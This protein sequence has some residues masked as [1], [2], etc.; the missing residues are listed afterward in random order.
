[1]TVR[2]FT[3]ACGADAVVNKPIA[4]SALR[5][6][7]RSLLQQREE[8]SIGVSCCS[9]ASSATSCVTSGGTS[10]DTSSDV[11]D[12]ARMNGVADE[13]MGDEGMPAGC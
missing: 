7:V 13:E 11:E 5:L 10:S 8:G 4:T 9:T 1:M 2:E 3:L 12:D 6:V